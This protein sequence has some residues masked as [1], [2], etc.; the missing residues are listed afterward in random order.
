[1]Q[2]AAKKTQ[3]TGSEGL[4]DV[5]ISRRERDHGTT[6]CI[7]PRIRSP[8]FCSRDFRHRDA[9]LAGRDRTWGAGSF[10][11]GHEP[12]RGIPGYWHSRV[13]GR[14]GVHPG[15]RGDHR[16]HDR[17]ETSAST[18]CCR[19]RRHRL[20]RDVDHVVDCG[21]NRRI[22]QREYAGARFAGGDGTSRRHRPAHHH[23]LVF[24]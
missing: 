1:M 19:R 12:N 8:S 5:L 17:R 20:R 4:A 18:A 3:P 2:A 11:T 23:E 9:H 13:S 16:K 10:A 24:S 6:L 7:P 21:A 22:T 14:T 15:A